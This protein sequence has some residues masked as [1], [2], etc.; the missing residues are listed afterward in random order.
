MR[1]LLEH[2]KLTIKSSTVCIYLACASVHAVGFL[3]AVPPHSTMS[4][5]TQT[6]SDF[7]LQLDIDLQGMNWILTGNPQTA[8]TAAYSLICDVNHHPAFLLQDEHLPMSMLTAMQKY[9]QNL[10]A[11]AVIVSQSLKMSLQLFNEDLARGSRRTFSDESSTAQ[12]FDACLVVAN[13]CVGALYP[14]ED[15]HQS[16]PTHQYNQIPDAILHLKDGTMTVHVEHKRVTVFQK[17]APRI[18]QFPELVPKMSGHE[19]GARSIFFK[20][21]TPFLP[22]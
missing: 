8:S 14:E 22:P 6:L 11:A 20:V 3:K 1:V 15:I 17:H 18:L 4:N 13:R 5:S 12:F 7:L 16:R 9:L 10:P 21:S 19:T 2:Q